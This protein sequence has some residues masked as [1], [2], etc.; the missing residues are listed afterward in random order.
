MAADELARAMRETQAGHH[1]RTRVLQR[2]VSQLGG[3][4]DD[5]ERSP[6]RQ[7]PQGRRLIQSTQDTYLAMRKV[8]KSLQ[9]ADTLV[10]DYRELVDEPDPEKLSRLGKQLAVL[11][12]D[13]QRQLRGAVIAAS[14][15]VSASRPLAAQGLSPR[16]GQA[17]HEIGHI[18]ELIERDAPYAA[19]QLHDDL[20]GMH[21]RLARPVLSPPDDLD[22][23][24]EDAGDSR[25][26]L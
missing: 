15:A 23:G 14:E 12:E 6:L 7:D 1:E 22:H 25:L 20:A 21:H 16:L 9:D 17:V 26:G 19:T 10:H 18:T 4:L 24:I 8:V 13:L 2:R 5:I 3:L 11:H